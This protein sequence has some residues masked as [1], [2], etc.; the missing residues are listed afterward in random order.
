MSMVLKKFRHVGIV[1]EN[2]DRA[3]DFYTELGLQVVVR[4]IER[5]PY[6]NVLLGGIDGDIETV[7]L[8]LGDGTIVL[9]L[10]RISE[11]K[12]TPPRK[13]D[14]TGITHFALEVADVDEVYSRLGEDSFLSQP[15]TSPDGRYRV[16]FGKDPEGN[17]IEFVSQVGG[18]KN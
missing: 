4:Q 16:V 8:G 10:L 9:E 7:K 13:L 15:Q 12:I 3:L 11:M 6:V 2:L 18:W 1:V 5:K 17:C 14:Q